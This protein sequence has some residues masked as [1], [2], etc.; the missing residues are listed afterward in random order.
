MELLQGLDRNADGSI[1]NAPE[2]RLRENYRLEQ[3]EWAANTDT[4]SAELKEKIVHRAGTAGGRIFLILHFLYFYSFYRHRYYE[5]GYIC[6]TQKNVFEVVAACRG[7]LVVPRTMKKD[8]SG[9]CVTFFVIPVV[10]FF[11]VS[12]VIS[13]FSR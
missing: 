10:F 11:L 5:K 4:R 1:A 3:E 2:P 7:L 6:A 9:A 13:V 12:F 8:F